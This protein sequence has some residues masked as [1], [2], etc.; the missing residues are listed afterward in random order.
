MLLRAKIRRSLY[1]QTTHRNPGAALG[2]GNACSR[3]A[4]EVAF[5]KG[6]GKG[7]FQANSMGRGKPAL[8]PDRQAWTLFPAT[9][10][11]TAPVFV[12]N[13]AELL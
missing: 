6:G 10:A 8:G 13:C 12:H 9:E 2:G 3:P 7:L 5:L 11:S 1:T 4:G